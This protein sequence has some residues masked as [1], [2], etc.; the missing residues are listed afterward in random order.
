LR[1]SRTARH[2]LTWLAVLVIVGLGIHFLADFQWAETGRALLGTNVAILSAAILLSLLSPVSKATA[3]YVILRPLGRVRF[4]TAQAGTFLGMALAPFSGSVVGEGARARFLVARDGMSW[5]EGITSIL[6]LRIIEALG[7]GIFLV[8]A[9][10]LFSVPRPL[11]IAQGVA[12]AMFVVVFVLVRL[13]W[14]RT[15]VAHAPE[16]LQK[17]ANVVA[18]MGRVKSLPVLALLAVLNWSVQWIAYDLMLRAVGIPLGH[19]AAFIALVA[20]NLLGVLQLPA[21]NLGVFQASVVAAL[22]PFGVSVED[23]VAAGLVMQASL[24]LPIIAIVVAAFGV[25]GIIRLLPNIQ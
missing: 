22:A 2:V 19:Q 17:A 4:S 13:R 25:R 11:R 1:L 20:T 16:R 10:L 5:T 21:G 15:V 7:L 8:L 14:W 23:G 12:A 18:E 24:T 9:P 6:Y 3:W